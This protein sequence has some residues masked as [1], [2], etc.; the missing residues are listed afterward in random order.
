M[1]EV[2]GGITVDDHLWI[3]GRGFIDLQLDGQLSQ[4]D[5]VFVEKDL[6]LL[7]HAQRH[8]LLQLGVVA[9]RLRA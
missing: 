2:C 6:A 8:G 5:L 3:F 9:E 4:R 7:I 1:F